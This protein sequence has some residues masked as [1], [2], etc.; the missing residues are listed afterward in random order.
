MYKLG[1][2]ELNFSPINIIL[3]LT[4][5]LSGAG[6]WDTI[7]LSLESPAF[8]WEKL[9]DRKNQEMPVLRHI[10]RLTNDMPW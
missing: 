8:S 4:S 6:F 5:L 1:F 2:M 10:C 7:S 9:N 3:Y